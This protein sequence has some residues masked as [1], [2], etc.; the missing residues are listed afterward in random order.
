MKYILLFCLIS[1]LGLSQCK[2]GDSKD[3]DHRVMDS[4]KNKSSIPLGK[5]KVIPIDSFLT[6]NPVKCLKQG[7]YI[8]IR[9]YLKD[10][11]RAGKESCNCHSSN[12][13]HYDWHLTVTKDSLQTSRP[14]RIICEITPHVKLDIGWARSLKGRMVTIKG[15]A[16]YDLE[17]LHNAMDTN[18]TG[19]NVWRSSCWEIHPVTFIE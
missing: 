11:K 8:Q 5:A 3:P 13:D 12:K 16:F 2:Y 17:H 4:L 10:I 14:F 6:L 1:N 19:S 15:Y 7:D 18:P 9:V